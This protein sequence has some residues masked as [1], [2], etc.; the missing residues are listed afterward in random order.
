MGG[1]RLAVVEAGALR[2]GR[3]SDPIPGRLRNLADAVRR[4]I[5]ELGPDELALEEAYFGR[6]VQSALRIGE[7]RGVILAE[8]DRAGVAVSQFPP[9]RIKRSVTGNGSASKEQV[10]RMVVQVLRLDFDPP[11]RT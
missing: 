11:R 7:S 9:A 5:G 8:A 3:S 6:S 4:L 1:G 2:L 10:A